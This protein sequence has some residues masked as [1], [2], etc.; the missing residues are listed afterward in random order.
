MAVVSRILA[1]V[2]L[3]ITGLAAI[4]ILAGLLHWARDVHNDRRHTFTTLASTPV[5]AG[6]G[7]RACDTAIRSAICS[8]VPLRR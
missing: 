2:V 4:W 6:P 8:R 7:N 5:F 1:I 3:S